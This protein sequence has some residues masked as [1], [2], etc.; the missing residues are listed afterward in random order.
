MLKTINKAGD[1]AYSDDMQESSLIRKLKSNDPKISLIRDIFA[2]VII[3]AAIGCVLFSV[4]GIW[5]ALVAV[6]SGSMM[7]NMNIGDL[8]FVVEKNRF[9]HFRTSIEAEAAG[10]K[11]FND[12][13]DV[14]V[15]RPNGYTNM[16]PIIHRTLTEIN[17]SKALATNFAHAGYITK[18]DHNPTIDQGSTFLHIGVMQPVKEEWII[19]KALFAI[20]LVGHLPLHIWEFTIVVA[21][22]LMM[23]ELYSCKKEK[24]RKIDKKIRKKGGKK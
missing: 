15:Y 5:P 7:P 18:G 9:D 16:T 20:P 17:E 21:I 4:S 3:V 12:Y 23:W 22:L 2:V 11:S 24:S 19:G 6:E 8:V 14:I 10:V 13:G 1:N